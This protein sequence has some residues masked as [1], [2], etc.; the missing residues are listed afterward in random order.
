MLAKVASN[1]Q[2]L[3]EAL[4]RR[5]RRSVAIDNSRVQLQAYSPHQGDV[6][7]VRAESILRRAV[8]K[9]VVDHV[10]ACRGDARGL[11]TVTARPDLRLED[12]R[13]GH[14]IFY[15]D[16]LLGFLWFLSSDGPVT[17]EHYDAIRQAAADAALLMHRE[18]LQAGLDRD[19]EYRMLGDLLG[20]DETKRS[21][22]ADELVSEG[23]FVADSFAALVVQVDH[24]SERNE[25]SEADRL[26][27][28][29]ALEAVRSTRQS[30]HVLT[31]E[32]R[33]HAVVLAAEPVGPSAHESLA[34]LGE[35]L[36]EAT[37]AK[38]GA[39]HCWV[40]IGRPY[41]ELADAWRSYGQARRTATI[42]QQLRSL[43]HVS[44]VDQL[45][46]YELLGQ[47]PGDVLDSAV[48]P[49]LSALIDQH[50]PG[51]ALLQTLEVF[52]D[53]AGDVKAAAEELFVHRTSL[54]YRLRRIQDLTGLDLSS[55]DDRLIAHLGLKIAHLT[56]RI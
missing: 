39:P 4:A 33:D 48:H 20:E 9:D 36:R 2:Q 8:P 54:Y 45:G 55:G 26:A 21:A 6:D 25:T 34:A 27:T 23:L 32:R 50:T 18:F 24:R 43:P 44:R 5:M 41:R 40:G 14:P 49:G 15:R 53:H 12:P 37:A 16:A 17:E 30:R 19:R 52:L 35:A 11:F 3:A 46:V 47:V 51:D 28:A 22:A 38:S 10:Y 42:L 29:S 7:P 1:L 13:V 56:A 31:L